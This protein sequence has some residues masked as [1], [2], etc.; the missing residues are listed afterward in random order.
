[1]RI[2]F[3]IMIDIIF[4]KVIQLSYICIL[5]KNVLK[6]KLTINASDLTTFM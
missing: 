4:H 3:S 6:N 1:M 2:V 5:S